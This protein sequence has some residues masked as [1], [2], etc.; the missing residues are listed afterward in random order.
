MAV[1][2]QTYRPYE[3]PKTRLIWRFLI[4]L[5]YSYSRI[6]Q[7]RLL[8]LL[9]ATCMFYPM[10]CA[11]LIYLSHNSPA[12]AMLRLRSGVLPE[13]NGRFFLVYCTV[14][15]S[16][17]FVLT[18]LIGPSLIWPDL[19][20]GALTLL[21]SRPFS[22]FE[23]VASKIVVLLL[24]L[25]VITWLPGVV[26]FMIEAGCVG[27]DW[28]AEHAWL[29]GG[30]M[31][32]CLLWIFVLSLIALALS[33]SVRWRTAAGIAVLAVY[34]VGAGLGSAINE[35][36]RTHYGSLLDLRAV[37]NTIW[38]WL[39][40]YQDGGKLSVTEACLVLALVCALSVRVLARR[41]RGFEVAK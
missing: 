20:N 34:F 37:V 35:V 19:A 39:F 9:L 31:A 7:S 12:L 29:L 13:V 33:A 17:A 6:L 26:L 30:I 1:Y 24:L 36:W 4:P 38:A 40:R 25:S 2:K 15:G 5:R 10:A 18:A 14:Q 21:L 23:Y 32:A 8:V 27:W 28:A 22:R 11:A 16:L 41:V 3:G